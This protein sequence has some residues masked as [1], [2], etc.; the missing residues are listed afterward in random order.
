MLSVISV[1]TDKKHTMACCISL[2]GHLHATRLQI[3]VFCSL[4]QPFNMAMLKLHST[5]NFIAAVDPQ[6]HEGKSAQSEDSHTI[7]HL[8]LKMML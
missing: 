2:H 7:L 8:I 3:L 4:M 1:E 6:V 5:I